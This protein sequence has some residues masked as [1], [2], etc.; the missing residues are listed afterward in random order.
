[1]IAARLVIRIYWWVSA[2]ESLM[3]MLCALICGFR[4]LALTRMIVNSI[5][6]E[7]RDEYLDSSGR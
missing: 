6:I 5:L 2:S 7:S 4:E 1:M 3:E